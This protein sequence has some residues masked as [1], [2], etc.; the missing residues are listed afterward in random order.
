VE[1]NGSTFCMIGGAGNLPSKMA[2]TKSRPDIDAITC[3]GV[4]PYSTVGAGFYDPCSIPVVI[5]TIII[6][7]EYHQTGAFVT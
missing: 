2:R 4:T 7:R 5:I 3:V 6:P 1:S